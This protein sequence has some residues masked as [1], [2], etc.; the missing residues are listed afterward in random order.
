MSY[1]NSKE[2]VNS[3]GIS[4]SSRHRSSRRSDHERHSRQPSDAA[5]SRGSSTVGASDRTDGHGKARRYA[6]GRRRFVCKAKLKDKVKA[7][8]SLVKLKAIMTCLAINISLL[9]YYL[10]CNYR[11]DLDD[12]DVDDLIRAIAKSKESSN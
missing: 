12:V 7:R 5:S 6:T 2:N 11:A 8:S 9:A 1:L 4:E 3:D 10:A